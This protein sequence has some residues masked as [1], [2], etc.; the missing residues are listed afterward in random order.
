MAQVPTVR[1]Q[2]TMQPVITWGWPYDPMLVRWAYWYSPC[3]PFVS[4]SAY[5]Q[6]QVWE[7]RQE[8]FEELRRGQQTLPSVGMQNKGATVADRDGGRARS[9]TND[10]DVRPDY[11]DSGRIRDQYAVSGEVLPEFLDCSVRPFR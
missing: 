6:F 5:D 10:A 3:Y 2:T 9:S 8:R 4:W 7:R 1:A 11:I